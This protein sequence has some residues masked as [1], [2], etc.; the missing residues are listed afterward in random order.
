MRYY[1]QLRINKRKRAGHKDPHLMGF[2]LLRDGRISI[3]AWSKQ[4][5]EDGMH[6]QMT[7]RSWNSSS[8]KYS[9]GFLFQ[10]KERK[11]PESPNLMGGFTW[12]GIFYSCAAWTN[13]N[14]NNEKFFKL[15]FVE[16]D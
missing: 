16:D 1:G 2:G 8:K 7:I 3:A 10:V 14:E 15:T 4:N 5:E 12:N 6:L 13:T 9:H 11:T